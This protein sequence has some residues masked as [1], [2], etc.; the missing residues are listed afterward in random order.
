MAIGVYGT[1]NSGFATTEA[2]T[3][4]HGGETESLM[5]EIAQLTTPDWQKQIIDPARWRWKVNLVF[6]RKCSFCGKS[7]K[8]G[9]A[10]RSR[11]HAP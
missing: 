5:A 10:L 1:D 9:L 8:T 6:S 2:I 3:E 11:S 4:H 7:G